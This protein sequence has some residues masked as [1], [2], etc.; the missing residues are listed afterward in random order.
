MPA[1][2]RLSLR[3]CAANIDPNALDTR[4]FLRMSHDKPPPL[5]HLDIS[6]PQLGTFTA[7]MQKL[8]RTLDSFQY[9]HLVQYR[10]SLCTTCTTLSTAYDSFMNHVGRPAVPVPA[11]DAHTRCWRCIAPSDMCGLQNVPPGHLCRDRLRTPLTARVSQVWRRGTVAPLSR[12][13]HGVDIMS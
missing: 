10:P 13:L 11:R 12:V 1:L 7:S 9:R 4:E 6:S 8:F 5:T 3:N 2:R